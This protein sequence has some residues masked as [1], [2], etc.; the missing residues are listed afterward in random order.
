M[1]KILNVFTSWKQWW[2]I[3]A[4]IS[5]MISAYQQQ[6]QPHIVFIMV[7]D[8][9][10][11]DVSFHGSDQIPTPNIDSLAYKS[12]ILQ[13]YYSEA[14]CTP[15][16]TALLT[17]KYPM[18]LGMHGQPLF[19]SEDRGIP[20]KERL[21]PS[22]LKDLGYSTHLVGKWHVGMSK[23]E[24]L[25]M[26]RG[27]DHHYGMRGGYVDYYTYNKI[28]TWPNG[29]VQ[30]GLDLYD[31][32]TPQ[33]CEQRYIVDALT[34]K[35]VKIIH[36]HNASQ[37][38]FLH[39]THNAPHAGNAGGALQPPLYSSVKNSH[40]ANSN[41]R[42]Y[43]E[44]VTHVDRSVGK[45]VAALA[46]RGILD[47]TIIVFASDNGAPTVGDLRNWGVNLPFRG[48]KYTPWEGGVRVPAFI[49]QSSVRPSVWQGLMHITDWLPTLIAAAG[50]SV[51]TAI[52]GVNQWNSIMQDGKSKRNEVLIAIEDGS[53]SWAAY[54]AGDY[55]I[56]VGNVTG[57]SNGYYGAE[58]MVNKRTP[59]EYYTAL[60]TCDMTRAFE[61]IGIY[62]DLD[63]AR[64]TRRMATI[65]QEDTA[66]DATSCIPTPTR[67]CLYNVRRDPME[68][69]NL[70]GKANKIATLL[71]SRLRALWA[72]Q[73]RRGPVKL[74]IASDPSNFNYVWTP[75]IINNTTRGNNNSRP[76]P[77]DK[78]TENLNFSFNFNQQTTGNRN[79]TVA[80]V[81]N[82]EGT[83]GL[84]NFLCILKSVF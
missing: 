44:I 81:V 45:I 4:M 80:A 43:A 9:G 13:H 60:R 32:A 73:L 28:E 27:Y 84:K 6:G 77:N 56:V 40:I 34:E 72:S 83:T 76:K 71:T 57:L 79:T 82:C 53:N 59:P 12:V 11:N 67:G 46:D 10:W 66:R 29:R 62:L 17:G 55:K 23:P 61:Q 20:V 31:D 8:M 70:W 58:L 1:T 2:I 5:T 26:S 47:D 75:W 19:N 69:N 33:E 21:L 41:R 39:V 22:Y 78:R 24:Y 52:D 3:L 35:A 64:Q 63:Y 36:Y 68:S 15:A 74:D 18:R 42:L 30:L 54:R 49:W 16:R 51:P 14:I 37:P 50:G 65:K 25:P 38:L 48:K 7:D